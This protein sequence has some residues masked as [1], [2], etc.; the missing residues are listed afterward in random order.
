M[1]SAT[2]VVGPW[3]GLGGTVSV[4]YTVGVCR[5]TV[6]AVVDGVVV[7]MTEASVCDSEVEL[8]VVLLNFGDKDAGKGG[9]V[10]LVLVA[11]VVEIVS[12]SVVCDLKEKIKKV[13]NRLLT[14]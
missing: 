9:I 8:L 3:V 10:V 12:S 2:L 7:G 11:L 14:T 6:D 1:G 13:S 5:V 4:E